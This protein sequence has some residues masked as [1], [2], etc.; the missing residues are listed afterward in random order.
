MRFEEL[1]RCALEKPARTI[2]NR[3]QSSG[4]MSVIDFI[5]NVVGLLLWLNWRAIPLA[6]PARGGTSLASTLKP[7][8]P[9]R[10]RVW[11]LAALLLL[12]PVRALFYWQVGEPIHWT[13]RI[14]LGPMTFWFRSDIFGRML[15]FSAL[16]FAVALGIFYLCLLLL[17][18]INGQISD[19]DP[20]QRLVRAHLG[21]LDRWPGALKLVL[22]L[23]FIAAAWCALNPVLVNLDMLPRN[24]HSFWRIAAQGAVIGLAAY[25]VLKYLLVAILA[26]YLVNSYVYLGELPLWEFVNATAR[27]L[28]RPL[29]R[30]PLQAGKI[31]FAP[32]L[33]IVMVLAAAH[34][35]LPPLTE[36][37]RKLN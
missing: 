28:L 10:P 19:A 24:E 16:S 23:F 37:Y 7:A 34:F 22:P 18:W 15:L 36:L 27:A 6:V 9:P 21:R 11:Y 17:S 12:L 4:A 35:S 1:L 25:L 30:L 14:P 32:V 13:P 5:L 2:L 26:M 33:A 31:D 3:R 8:G 20:A 29:R